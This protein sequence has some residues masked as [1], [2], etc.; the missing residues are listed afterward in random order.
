LVNPPTAPVGGRGDR[1]PLHEEIR[2]HAI[3]PQPLPPAGNPR[4]RVKPLGPARQLPLKPGFQTG[5]NAMKV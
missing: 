5:T 4:I 1:Y 2:R 3:C